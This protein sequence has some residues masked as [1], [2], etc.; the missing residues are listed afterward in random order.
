VGRKIGQQWLSTPRFTLTSSAKEAQNNAQARQPLSSFWDP[1]FH[2]QGHF[3]TLLSHITLLGYARLDTSGDKLLDPSLETV[4][5]GEF[6]ERLIK[7]ALKG[8][9]RQGDLSRIL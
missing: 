1:V 9:H 7:V 6:Y 5:L 2:H 3:P 4:V 8:I